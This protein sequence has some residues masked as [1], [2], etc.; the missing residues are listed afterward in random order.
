MGCRQTRVDQ[1]D[2][3]VCDIT[4]HFPSNFP[5]VSPRPANSRDIPVGHECIKFFQG[6]WNDVPMGLPWIYHMASEVVLATWLGS[7][8][9]AIPLSH[10][11]APSFCVPNEWRR[12]CLVNEC[13]II[14]TCTRV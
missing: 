10:L 8:L 1:P 5:H 2:T 4:N 7:V 14:Q 11:E 13:R 6:R 9:L 12:V 3:C